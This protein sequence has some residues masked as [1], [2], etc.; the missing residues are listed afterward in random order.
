MKIE[1]TF[2][3]GGP[4]PTEDLVGREDTL[5]SLFERTFRHGN[6]IVLTGSR[7][8]GKTSVADELLRRV[9]AGGGIGV[10]ID[11][12]RVTG[13][14]HELAEVIARATYDAAAGLAGAFTRLKD[15]ISSAPKPVLFQGDLNLALAFFGAQPVSDTERLERALSLADEIAREKGRRCVVVYDEF[16]ILRKVD[17]DIFTPV[18]A[19]LQHAMTNTAYLFLGS[20]VHLMQELFGDPGSLPFG[21][22]VPETLAPPGRHDWKR[23]IEERFENL[24]APLGTGEA[25]DLIDFTGG[26]PRDLMEACEHLLTIRSINPRADGA[27][28][29]AME[30]TLNSLTMKFDELWRRLEDIPGA[31]TTVVRIATDRPVYGSGRAKTSVRRG[32]DALLR[33][34]IIRR[35]ARGAFEFAEPLFGRYVCS[36][37]LE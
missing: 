5:R 33:E 26:H 32:I 4:V 23:Y 12:S 2:P 8:V 36:L 31:Q 16:S 37:A 19:V 28:R 17:R 27:L 13:D 10:Y 21:L 20:E 14:R 22:A 18:R 35:T 3:T 7:Q 34:G 24:G 15:F 11:C 25:D 30:K 29:L 6:S 9:R 1:R